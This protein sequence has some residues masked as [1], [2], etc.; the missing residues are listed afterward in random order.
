MNSEEESIP[1]SHNPDKD[2]HA[3]TALFHCESNDE[4]RQLLE[5]GAD[6]N[7]R[8][9]QGETALFECWK[10]SDKDFSV[11]TDKVIE[12]Y[13]LL[14]DAQADINARCNLG[15]TVLLEEI[16]IGNARICEYLLSR[17]ASVRIETN[18][19]MT[20][21]LAAA[22]QRNKVICKML[23]S[24]LEELDRGLIAALHCLKHIKNPFLRFLYTERKTLLRPHL[25]HGTL[26]SL[27]MQTNE[28]G[29]LAHD[30]FHLKCLVPKRLQF[31]EEDSADDSE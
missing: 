16:E 13:R 25:Q 21:L 7:I 9:D 1:E 17:G 26:A 20:P 22:N 2:S 12:R 31:L 24:H 23:V 11:E 10:I 4:C 3:E 15:Y 14:L 5:A 8:N 18:N 27:L 6:V 30:L 29:K 19:G 28:Y